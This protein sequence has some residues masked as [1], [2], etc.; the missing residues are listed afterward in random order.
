MFHDE[1]GSITV[2]DA[3][4]LCNCVE[5]VVLLGDLYDTEWDSATYQPID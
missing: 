1:D 3:T 2:T 5:S 4:E